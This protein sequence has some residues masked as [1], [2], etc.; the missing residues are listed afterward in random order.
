[1]EIIPRLKR[2]YNDFT[3]MYHI[4]LA[5]N[6]KESIFIQDEDKEKIMNEICK[7]KNYFNFEVYA[8]CV[9]NN[10]IHIVIYDEEIQISK[11]IHRLCTKYS[12]YYNKKYFRTGHVFQNRFFSKEIK[13]KTY[14]VH[15]CRYIHLNPYSK[16]MESVET[17]KWCSYARYI[18]KKSSD[19]LDANEKTKIENILKKERLLRI[20][21]NNIEKF[22]EY[23]KKYSLK[24][25]I[26]DKL[27]YEKIDNI[28]KHDVIRYILSVLE[29]DS[30]E[31]LSDYS[32]EKRNKEL[33]KLK[34][35]KY[36]STTQ[37]ANAIGMSARTL[38]RIFKQS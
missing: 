23:H 1:M 2:R 3:K 33:Y 35:I 38:Q 8:Y 20:F 36:I 9:M 11:I 24:R 13:E 19:I 14:F 7:M 27:E 25:N 6:N 34:K 4:I 26:I 31:K 18:D 15:L 32:I 17:Y 10:H 12:I 29:I 21:N 16:D 22:K 37:I 5:G 28:E 30:I